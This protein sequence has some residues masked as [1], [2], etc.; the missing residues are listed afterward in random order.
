MR[1]PLRFI[2]HFVYRLP[3]FNRNVLEAEMKKAVIYARYSTG[4]NQ[5]DVSI[6]GQEK[7]CTNYIERHGYIPAG[8]YA[9][10][11]ISGRTDKR[12]HFQQMIDDARAGSIDVVVVYSLDRFSRD[13]YDSAIYK[14][15]LRDHGVSVESA[16]ESIPDG[17]EGILFEGMLEAMAEYYSAELSKKIRRGMDVKASKGLSVGGPTPFGYVL[18]DGAYEA[19]PKAA[20]HVA[21]VFSM[22]LSGS[23]LVACAEYLNQ[24]GFTTKNKKPYSGESIKRMLTNKKYIGYYMYNGLE[25][26]GGMPQLVPEDVFYKVQRKMKSNKPRKPRGEYALSGKLIC[27]TCGSLMQGTSGTG[28]VGTVHYYYKCPGKDRKPVKRDALE[29]AVAQHVRD[30][31]NDP[32]SLNSLVDKLYDYQQEERLSE[33]RYHA[34][35]DNLKDVEKQL[36]RALDMVLEQGNVP[37]LA[38]RIRELDADRAIMR[39]D[40]EKLQSSPRLTKDLI[41]DGLRL[42]LLS[43]HVS[44]A[45]VIKIFVHQVV[46]Y[47]DRLLIEFNFHG[48]NGLSRSVLLGFEQSGEWCTNNESDRIN[49]PFFHFALKIVPVIRQPLTQ[50]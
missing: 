49:Y 16:S 12:P 38:D 3:L 5:T 15:V 29:H 42:S 36:E 22:Y 23:T 35:S 30:I 27:G 31:L 21:E 50:T 34:L 2:H 18:K 26:E 48:S 9:D 17:P 1:G 44:D 20:P 33:A 19:D 28:K 40:L 37:G 39:A 11:H 41:R 8:M 13:K 24:L 6:E 7:I 43:G 4:P 46:L 45:K 47:D 10:R 32:E 14:K 25:I